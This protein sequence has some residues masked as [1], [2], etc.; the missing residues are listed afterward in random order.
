VLTVDEVERILAVPDI[1]S[2]LGLRDR[3]MLETFYATAIR[4][5]ELCRLK[6]RNLDLKRGVLAVRQGK[7]R[8]DR[9]VPVGERATAWI[10]KYLRESRPEL[11]GFDDD[12]TLFLSADGTSIVPDHLGEIVRNAITLAE[13]DKEGACHLFRHTAA[14][15]MLEGGADIRFI[16]Q[17]LGHAKLET[18]QIYTQV[19]LDKLKAVHRA[20]H[21]GAKLER[22]PHDAETSD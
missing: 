6:V 22:R 3:A 10:E 9:F 17:M 15:L 13:V 1:S 21:P 19:S 18:T 4:R 12:G 20:T 8:K 7:G 16:Q 5:S 2:L 11:Q 14:T